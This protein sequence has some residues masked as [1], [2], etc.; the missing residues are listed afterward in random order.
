MPGDLLREETWAAAPEPPP[1]SGTA[2][3]PRSRRVQT[4]LVVAGPQEGVGAK[5]GGSSQSQQR[6]R[7]GLPASWAPSSRGSAAQRIPGIPAPHASLWL[8]VPG[9]TDLITT[10]VNYGCKVPAQK[11]VVSCGK[12]RQTS[13]QIP[14]PHTSAAGAPACPQFHSVTSLMLPPALR[15]ER[16]TLFSAHAD[17]ECPTG[18]HTIPPP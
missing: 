7:P 15:T 10:P 1:P 17:R 8:A 18:P 12:D 14:P 13:P 11:G 3:D 2:E 9:D 4:G 6:S 5:G 16:V